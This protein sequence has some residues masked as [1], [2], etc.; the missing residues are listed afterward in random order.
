MRLNLIKLLREKGF[1]EHYLVN[2]EKRK[3]RI[4]L[5]YGEGRECVIHGLKRISSPGLRRYV[6][7]KEIPR[8]LGGMGMAILSTPQGVIDD[9]TARKLKVGGELICY[10]W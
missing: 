7:Y 5:K 2:E 9:E 3:I 8:V 10:I 6:G 1:I 4:I